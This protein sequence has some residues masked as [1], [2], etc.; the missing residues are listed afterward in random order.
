MDSF[1]LAQMLNKRIKTYVF[2]GNSFDIYYADGSKQT[3]HSDNPFKDWHFIEDKLLEQKIEQIKN[4]EKG[5]QK[6]E[7]QKYKMYLIIKKAIYDN[8]ITENDLLKTIDYDTIYLPPLTLSNVK[9]YS[10]R[11]IKKM[12]KMIKPQRCID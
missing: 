8:K 1:N 7:L 9:C 4:V 11:K 12:F 5:K 10:Y 2:L 3:Y 6:K